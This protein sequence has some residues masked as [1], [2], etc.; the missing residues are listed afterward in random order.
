MIL[1]AFISYGCF[2]AERVYGTPWAAI[3][4]V[5]FPFLIIN[6]KIFLYVLDTNPLWGLCMANIISDFVTYILIFLNIS[7]D[8]QKL[9]NFD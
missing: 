3:P 5:G 2:P 8:E 6:L 9:F 7:L 1:T 4:G